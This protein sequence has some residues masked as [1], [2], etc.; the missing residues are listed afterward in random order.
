VASARWYAEAF[1]TQPALAEKPALGNRYNA[2]CAAALV[3]GGLG[4]DAAD[5]GENERA[6]WRRQ[7]LD[8]L[9][10]D[11]DAWRRLQ[12]KSSEQARRSIL[13][14]LQHW[15]NDRDLESVR[16][17]Q[18]LD[19]LPETERAEWQRLWQEVEMLRQ[20]TTALSGRP[21]STQANE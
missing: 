11:L 16:R 6:R 21:P 18:A 17:K 1:T 19:K 5:L 13:Q 8:W 15:K 9:R 20:Q 14:R 4:V 2:A 3:S 10:A 12:E 7:A